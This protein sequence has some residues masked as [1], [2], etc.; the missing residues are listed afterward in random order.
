MTYGFTC[1]N[2]NNIV[3]ISDTARGHVYLGKYGP[4]TTPG[5]FTVDVTCAGFPTVFIS[6]PYNYTAGDGGAAGTGAYYGAHIRS[7]AFIRRVTHLGGTAWR[8]TV[9]AVNADYYRAAS[10]GSGGWS[11]MPITLRVFGRLD[12]NYPSG[13]PGNP[14]G[15][16]V[17]DPNGGLVFDSN[18]RMLRLA[19]NTY[20]VEL[21]LKKDYPGFSGNVRAEASSYD[22]SVSLP[23]SMAG[24]SIQATSRAL[25]THYEADR[26]EYFDGTWEY[27]YVTYQWATGYWASGSTLYV[28]KLLYGVGSES[29]P[30]TV[31][32]SNTAADSYTRLA[33]IDD[34]QFP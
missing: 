16:R 6:V 11:P 10:Q 19:G 25:V 1:K 24:K 26:A 17:W 14:Y 29:F 28:R 27:T 12:L 20:D 34:S 30:Y 7:G 33:V 22:T 21:L 4:Y 31:N 3:T 9:V 2:T 8:I 5:E 13:V 18:A 32:V 23:F 15:M